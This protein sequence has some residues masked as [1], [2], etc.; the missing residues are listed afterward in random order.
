MWQPHFFKWKRSQVIHFV[1]R[2]FNCLF[3]KK[4]KNVEWYYHFLGKPEIWVKI[5]K[6]QEIQWLLSKKNFRKYVFRMYVFD[7]I[8]YDKNFPPDFWKFLLKL[9]GI[10]KLFQ[11][12]ISLVISFNILNI[13]HKIFEHLNEKYILVL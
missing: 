7:K 10:S 6:T 12:M 8:F 3:I 2:A 13:L 5:F 4:I 11:K 1:W 9:P